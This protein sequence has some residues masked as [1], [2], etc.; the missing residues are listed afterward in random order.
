MCFR[1]ERQLEQLPRGAVATSLCGRRAVLVTL[2]AESLGTGHRGDTSTATRARTKGAKTVRR[3]GGETRQTALPGDAVPSRGTWPRR[4]CAARA[5]CEAMALFDSAMEGEASSGAR[6]AWGNCPRS[7]VPET[8]VATKTA[9]AAWG[10]AR[11]CLE[12]GEST[13]VL[14]ALIQKQQPR[15]ALST[16]Q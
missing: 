9:R 14:K 10:T 2:L 7:A 13:R 6:A 16:V 4:T 11:G 1:K 3:G 12:E 15:A 5:S 8:S